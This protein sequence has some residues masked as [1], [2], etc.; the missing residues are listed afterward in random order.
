MVGG[1]NAGMRDRRS[2]VLHASSFLRLALN[3]ATMRISLLFV[4]GSVLTAG[5][6][7]SMTVEVERD[8]TVLVPEH[9]S[10]AWRPR[11]WAPLGES[12]LHPR[13]DNPTARERVER[14]I[15]AVLRDKSLQQV[16]PEVAD[17]LVDYRMGVWEEQVKIES[18]RE[19]PP[20]PRSA[21]IPSPEALT[22]SAARMRYEEG[23]LLISVTERTT[24]R[25]AFRAA[26]QRVLG[27]RPISDEAL[28]QAMAALLERFP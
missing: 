5:G 16:E 28:Q 8:A 22:G 19:V 4:I 13:V 1:K 21:E 6:C 27:S 2:G 9:A 15:E 24:G 11:P 17:F 26:G 3:Q 23:A 25:L 18:P 14:A 20:S 7:V 10:W 12:E